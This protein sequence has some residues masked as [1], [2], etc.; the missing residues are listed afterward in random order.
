MVRNEDVVWRVMEQEMAVSSLRDD[1]GRV[2]V[3]LDCSIN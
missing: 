2:E 3:T 1:V